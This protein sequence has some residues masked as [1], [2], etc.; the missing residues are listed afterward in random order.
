LLPISLIIA[1]GFV[2]F[3]AA[4]K[5]AEK[6]NIEKGRIALQGTGIVAGGALGACIYARVKEQR[7]FL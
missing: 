6:F 4:T 7:P 3:S 1:G 5:A 2:G